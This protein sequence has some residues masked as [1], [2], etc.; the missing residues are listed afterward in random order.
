[1]GN[2]T[3]FRE[4]II[5]E[6]K[7]NL[8]MDRG[9]LD[10]KEL[11]EQ[12]PVSIVAWQKIN[13]QFLLI[14]FNKAAFELTKGRIEKLKSKP[15]SGFKSSKLAALIEECYIS[16]S[17]VR[18]EIAHQLQTTGEFKQ[19]KVTLCCH[20][21][22][23]VIVHTVDITGERD[24][25][26]K[27]KENNNRVE[28][29]LNNF[30]DTI[31]IIDSYGVVLEKKGLPVN[32]N[33]DINK[34]IYDFFHE[35]L[36][37][38]IARTI[39]H[40]VSK[41]VAK[42]F[43][44]T[45][46]AEKL[47][48]NYE[49]RIIPT[50]DNLLLLIKR[51][52]TEIKDAK[53]KYS[54]FISIWDNSLDGMRLT[55]SSGN[56]VAVNRAYCKMVGMSCSDLVGKPFYYGT[57]ATFSTYEKWHKAYLKDFDNGK[58]KLFSEVQRVFQ[59][60]KL[61]R[62]QVIRKLVNNSA[63]SNSEKLLLTIF[64]D[65]TEL[66]LAEIMLKENLN[67]SGVSKMSAYLAH[68]IKTP[69]TSIK[70][71]LTVL[72]RSLNL[73]EPQAKSFSMLKEEVKRLSNLLKDVLHFSRQKMPVLADVNLYLLLE[74]INNLMAPILDDK[75]ISIINRLDNVVVKGDAKELQTLFLQLIENSIEAISHHG[76]IE[77]YSGIVEN[78]LS[79]KIKD[80]GCGIDKAEQVFEPFFTTK[81]SGT[82][83]GLAI[84][85]KIVEE[86][87]GELKLLS[88]V[89]GETVFELKFPNFKL[90]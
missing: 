82:G 4:K 56:T 33:G 75:K 86:H 69:L 3:T 21:N 73:S 25:K 29:I 81:D 34:T 80:S 74:Y 42:S 2:I 67:I 37:K 65:V 58:V 70:M 31:F 39:F 46:T 5:P 53:L 12:I 47:P 30:P 10:F 1:M 13:G 24:L 68:E 36:R 7:N 83:L 35:S 59:D 41:N 16:K 23:I 18:S 52:V 89:E 84:A 32:L 38:E 27:L 90:Q 20:N 51:D 87:S 57:K 22:D 15:L 40:A 71:N 63:E 26:A 55:D 28:K 50:K 64:R 49:V 6:E 78:N 11:Y 66:R 14:Y 62:L 76:D 54:Q 60:D 85:R 88:S 77:I 8:E 45:C 61:K 9:T 44:Y 48:K 19:L 79:I 43:E 72:S 17:T